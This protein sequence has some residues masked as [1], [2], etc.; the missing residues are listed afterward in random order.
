MHPFFHAILILGRTALWQAN[1]NERDF[2]N[3]YDNLVS[4]EVARQQNE[5]CTGTENAV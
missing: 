2:R 5:H 3:L 4:E 1:I